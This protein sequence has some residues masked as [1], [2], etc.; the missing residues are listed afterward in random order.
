M[1]QY[2]NLEKHLEKRGL[3]IKEKKSKKLKKS[4]NQMNGIEKDALLE[5]MA[6][7]LGYLEPD[8]V[9]IDDGKEKK[10]KK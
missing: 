10:D 7:D 9:I 8:E 4:F 6:R 1:G 2:V 3:K 5:E